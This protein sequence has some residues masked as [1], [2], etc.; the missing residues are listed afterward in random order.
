[1]SVPDGATQRAGDR[2]LI[3][4]IVWAVLACTVAL[5]LAGV[6]RSAERGRSERSLFAFLEADVRRDAA[7]SG[8]GGD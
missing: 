6:I 7:G 2:M 3:V 8:A 4:V 1:M 5:V